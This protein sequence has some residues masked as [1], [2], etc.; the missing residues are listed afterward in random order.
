MFSN[1][2]K[3][4]IF[5]IFG[6]LLVAAVGISGLSAWNAIGDH[7][8]AI[9]TELLARLDRELFNSTVSV[10]NQRGNAQS[11]LLGQDDA[12][13]AVD[14][15]KAFMEKESAGAA[16]AVQG[17]ELANP[18]L[19]AN[20][21]TSFAGIAPHF[22]ALY[23][24]AAKPRSAR[25]LPPTQAWYDATTK[26]IDALIAISASVSNEVWMGDPAIAELVQVRRFAWTIRDRYG[27]QCSLVRGNINDSTPLTA[28]QVTQM[29]EIGGILR[30]SWSMTDEIIARPGAPRVVVDAVKTARGQVDGALARIEEAIK[31]MDGSGKP[32][33]TPP[34][35]NQLCQ[36]PFPAILAVANAALDGAIAR[37][38]EIRAEALRT[39][40]IAGIVLAAM[41]ALCVFG[42]IAIRRRFAG[43]VAQ[44]LEVI[45]R[46]GDR[47]YA[48][49][50]PAMG[51][52]E[53][54]TMAAA[55]DQLRAGAAEGERLAKAEAEAR[56][57]QVERASALDK[58]CRS[59]EGDADRT[60]GELRGSTETLRS[61]ADTMRTLAAD[62]RGQ[63]EIV[64]RAARDATESVNTVAAATEELSS[65][66]QEISRQV[67]VSS[68][69]AKEAV[70]HVANTNRVVEA[71]NTAAQKIGD[72]VKLIAQIASQTNL[73]AL[74][75][76]IEA[77]RAG[78]A[79]K[80]FAVV[81]SEVKGLATQTGKATEDIS[82]QVSE[83]Q[84]AT[85]EAV[86]AI[87]K[88][89]KAIVGIDQNV[90]AIAAAVEEQGAATREISQNVQQVATGTREVTDT[91][92]R[93]AAASGK[94]GEA[95]ETVS[96]AVDQ[97]NAGAKALDGSVETFLADVK[98]A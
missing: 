20:L 41:A 15:V 87:S 63:A 76:T 49:P 72:V 77:A 33:L 1:S 17:V 88:V 93:V 55:L 10:R 30:T 48:S 52:D 40:A 61:V 44:L 50:V 85:M 5:A 43:P 26:Y 89:N 35:W 54:G 96:A 18:A 22:A 80:G 36:G 13:R 11:A 28:R 59:F 46:L 2:V 58:R 47:D 12:K 60:L 21:A 75:A 39:L 66:I 25:A 29:T 92:Q 27:I 65:S 14:D 73:L 62:S 56:Q 7:R 98:A 69:N 4:L 42:V 16:K 84:A 79:G 32:I 74:N 57:K 6:C 97:V 9:R 86:M 31:K 71:L 78:E 3:N 83:I 91:I 81:A 90:S 67:Q 19:A 64:S 70:E 51:P 68:D 38:E 82:K 23:A 37:A 34:E 24:E 8:Q 45:A 53:F 95:A 94:T